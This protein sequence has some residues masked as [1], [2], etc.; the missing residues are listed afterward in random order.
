MEDQSNKPPPGLSLSAP[1]PA[2]APAA[3][4][5]AEQERAYRNR[6]SGSWFDASPPSYGAG[7]RGGGR[8]GGGRSGGGGSGRDRGLGF[9]PPPMHFPP[10]PVVS[11]EQQ[12]QQPRFS[13]RAGTTPL[14]LVPIGTRC[15]GVVAALRES[16][17]FIRYVCQG[18]DDGEKEGE[19][20]NRKRR[21]EKLNPPR[22]SEPLFPKNKTAPPISATRSSSTSARSLQMERT[23]KSSSSSSSS[24][25]PTGARKGTSSS[26]SRATLPRSSRRAPRSSSPWA[27]PRA[28]PGARRPCGSRPCPRGRWTRTTSLRRGSSGS[29]RGSSAEEEEEEAAA[30]P[31]AAAA[32]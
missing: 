14:E 15:T 17:G 11:Q 21:T 32:E 23:E 22:L 26:S 4:P 1:P 8:G 24:N 3:P 19:G 28:A 16:F 25:N 27:L 13:V 7:R 6:S 29:W 20:E 31:P 2:E 12:Q 18:V 5:T 10:P 9:A 30:P